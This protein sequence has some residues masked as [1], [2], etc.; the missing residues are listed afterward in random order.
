MQ[1]IESAE[2]SRVPAELLWPRSV[3]ARR[4]MQFPV[5]LR[6]QLPD[7]QSARNCLSKAT[8]VWHAL[9]LSYSAGEEIYWSRF[10]SKCWS[11]S[12]LL[13]PS[14]PL[15]RHKITS[16]SLKE[17]VFLVAWIFTYK[18]S[19]QLYLTVSFKLTWWV[20][21]HTVKWSDLKAVSWWHPLF[22]VA[23]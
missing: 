2:Y 14:S 12:A 10:L 4:C 21:L 9:C 3:V 15:P 8:T 11:W 18:Q 17:T 7:V 23:M 22:Q 20:V 16:V 6:G 13:F 5:Q 1:D 19:P